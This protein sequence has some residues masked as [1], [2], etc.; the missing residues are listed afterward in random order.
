MKKLSSLAELSG[1]VYST[2]AGRHCPECG[3]PLAACA[4]AVADEVLGDGQVRVTRERKGR[5]GKVVTVVT[6]LPVTA[7]QLKEMCTQLKKTCGVGGAVKDAAIE[8]QGDQT[9]KVMTWLAAQGH[10]AKRVG[11]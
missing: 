2:D 9:E 7:A 4:C 1:L 10:P 3:Q 8:I 6:G 5:G 11:G